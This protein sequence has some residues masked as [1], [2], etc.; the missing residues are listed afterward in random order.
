MA[1]LPPSTA[2][3]TRVNIERYLSLAENAVSKN[4]L[5][6]SAQTANHFLRHIGQTGFQNAAQ[7][8]SFLDSP[9]GKI[10]RAI[11]MREMITGKIEEEN[12]ILE[13][14]QQQLHDEHVAFVLAAYLLDETEHQ[15]TIDKA[16][17]EYNKKV[18]QNKPNSEKLLNDSTKLIQGS[19]EA[20]EKSIIHIDARIQE[21]DQEI[22]LLDQAVVHC[23]TR[24]MDSIYALQEVAAF[25][26]DAT[27]EAIDKAIQ[28]A[29]LALGITPTKDDTYT[30]VA[31]TFDKQLF[32]HPQLDPLQLK[33]E[34]LN[35]ARART[36]IPKPEMQ[37]NA[38]TT[39]SLTPSP[40]LTPKPKIHTVELKELLRQQALN[41]KAF[42]FEDNS[43][44]SLLATR[45]IT[46]YRETG[47][48]LGKKSTRKKFEKDGLQGEKKQHLERVSS[49]KEHHQ[50]LLEQF[51]RLGARYSHAK[52]PLTTAPSHDATAPRPHQ[53][54]K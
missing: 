45:V 32:N 51:N 53:M 44:F 16:V 28:E 14:K 19:V 24:F 6:I 48:E 5:P 21:V 50:K 46:T 40:A 3:L 38:S 41:A 47:D 54:R 42:G 27:E 17:E 10:V 33:L 9:A 20:L 43:A 29:E 4:E 26:V 12:A 18:T 30:Y 49:L 25:V 31:K 8:L 1:I 52:T 23:D 35:L 11:I 13:A 22:I 37:P 2:S 34:A 7:V 15:K 39:P 36:A